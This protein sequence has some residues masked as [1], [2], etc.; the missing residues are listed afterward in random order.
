MRPPR[1]TAIGLGLLGCAWGP[2]MRWMDCL[3]NFGL[4]Q[5]DY[6]CVKP[7]LGKMVNFGGVF[8]ILIGV[9][10]EPLGSWL[11]DLTSWDVDE[12]QQCGGWIT[13]ITFEPLPPDF[14]CKKP[15]LGKTVDL[16]CVFCPFR[17][18]V[19]APEVTA[20]GIGRLGRGW[21]LAKWL[22]DCLA[23][24]GPL[25]PDFHCVKP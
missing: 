17:G 16:E 21:G 20:R 24:F 5:P 11:G 3:A 6:N 19:G 9:W 13:W 8:S 10:W 25:Q 2:T 18:L 4:L 14:N 23:N 15:C 7:L 1:I 22:M 12:V